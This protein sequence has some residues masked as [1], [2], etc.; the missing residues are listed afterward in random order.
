MPTGL[1]FHTAPSVYSRSSPQWPAH[2]RSDP[3]QPAEHSIS[4]SLQDVTG[5]ICSRALHVEL[6]R[7][8]QGCSLTCSIGRG[9]RDPTTRLEKTGEVIGK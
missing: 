1:G 6:R 7:V 3:Q 4:E 8:N 5:S 2:P 9:C